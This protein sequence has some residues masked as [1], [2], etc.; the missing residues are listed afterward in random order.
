MASSIERL[1]VELTRRLLSFLDDAVVARQD[2]TLPRVPW[3]L[4]RCM[5]Q[6]SHAWSIVAAELTESVLETHELLSFSV[7][8]GPVSQTQAFCRALERRRTPLRSLQLTLDIAA[9]R[10]SFDVASACGPADRF[11]VAAIPWSAVFERCRSLERL[12]LSGLPLRSRHVA[13]AIDAASRYCPRL[14][15]LVLPK[16]EWFRGP[17]RV[18]DIQAFLVPSLV[19]ALQRWT[20]QGPGCGLLELA[21]PGLLQLRADQSFGRCPV[22][23]LVAT[24][25]KYCPHL[26]AFSEWTNSTRD[27]RVCSSGLR[28][29]LISTSVW[30]SFCQSARELE[31]IDWCQLQPSHV[32]LEVFAAKLHPSLKRMRLPC[33]QS[34]QET[35]SGG[36]PFRLV[37]QVICSCPALEELVLC[38]DQDAH[39]LAGHHDSSDDSLLETLAT[40]CPQLRRLVMH[41][42]LNTHDFSFML[43][44][45]GATNCG[46][47][48]IAR[49][50]ELQDVT[51]HAGVST[52]SGLVALMVHAPKDRPI[53]RTDIVLSPS[54][55]FM[56]AKMP[57]FESIMTP[58][59]ND[60]V[61]R[62]TEL[63]GR[64][65]HLRIRNGSR[66]AGSR[67]PSQAHAFAVAV[68]QLGA[69]CPDI[70]I[71]CGRQ[72]SDLLTDVTL[73]TSKH[74]CQLERRNEPAPTTLTPVRARDMLGFPLA[75]S[76][77]AIC[78]ASSLLAKMTVS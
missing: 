34:L 43:S 64:R 14:R 2:S 56:D 60:L 26:R 6:V 11:D 35:T 62:A 30:E 5:R 71:R 68:E 19:D 46:L 3:K 12:D 16:R 4:L 55:P 17:L 77:V 8:E 23:H 53:R 28:R 20:E 76:C 45:C 67:T 47:Q 61:T 78:V 52:R 40:S 49:L 66:G 73:S 69:R 37:A 10:Q 63:H 75:L 24:I 9:I 22:D 27:A 57:S 1:P 42:D 18:G 38:C 59:L 41:Q 50:D 51:L 74:L 29:D 25:T 70:L 44:S 33:P 39:E 72:G 15:A 58:V 32:M 31:T 7:D 36:A 65:F 48:A 54:E 13:H 21:M